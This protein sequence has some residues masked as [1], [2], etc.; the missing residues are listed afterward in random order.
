MNET[1][2]NLVRAMKDVVR[3]IKP[4]LEGKETI[5]KNKLKSSKNKE[6]VNEI[7]KDLASIL[8]LVIA[9]KKIELELEETFIKLG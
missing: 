7:K 9:F 5:L 1:E 6:E 4:Y 8:N 2:M 3:L